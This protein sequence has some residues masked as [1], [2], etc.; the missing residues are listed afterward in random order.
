MI[1]IATKKPKDESEVPLVDLGE[2]SPEVKSQ[3][4]GAERTSIL[5]TPRKKLLAFFMF[6]GLS[7][8][9]AMDISREQT[10]NKDKK[11]IDTYRM[12][13]DDNIIDSMSLRFLGELE[14]NGS[15][16]EFWQIGQL[17]YS[18]FQKYEEQ[19]GPSLR[20]MTTKLKEKGIIQ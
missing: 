5:R 9:G 3:A 15:N 7:I 20:E 17:P 16:S 6:T 12:F 13:R 2:I 19:F 4:K 8:A 10:M 14:E 18:E 1:A 11:T